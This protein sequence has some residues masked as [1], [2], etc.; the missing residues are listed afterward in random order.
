LKAIQRF[1]LNGGQRLK[2]LLTTHQFLPEYS[3]GTEILVFSAAKELQRKGTD[4]YVFTGFPECNA[5]DDAG[6]F[7]SY[8]YDEI[9]VERF[10]YSHVPMGEQL[11]I[12]EAEYNNSFVAAY[13]RGFLEK[14]KPDIVHF[15][16]LQRLSASVINVCH[17]LGI[18]MVLTPTDFWFV[19]PTIQLL[20]TDNSIC[21]G[22]N[23]N[24]V[25]CLRH[26]VALGQP[27]IMQSM[28]QMMP[29]VLLSFVVRLL[30]KGIFSNLRV[31]T[32]VRAL[33]LRPEFLRDCLNK[34]DRVIVPSRLTENILK[35][36][37]LLPDRIVFSPF[38]IDLSHPI[39]PA[40]PRDPGKLRIGY[41][42][43]LLEHKGAHIL[44]KAA[45]SLPEK[46]PFELKIYGDTENCPDF[47][48][49]LQLIAGKDKR[50]EFCGT[51]PNDQ[52]GKILSSLDVLVVP[53]I[54]LENTPLVIYSAQAYGCP[55]IASDLG[56]MSELIDH[57]VN[58]LLFR[59]G[60]IS[61]LAVTISRLIHDRQ[62]LKK[63]S[64]N[65]RKPKSVA[66]YV[67]ELIMVYC[68]ILNGRGRL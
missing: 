45:C 12:D 39:Y 4:V 23:R 62:L 9:P 30:G 29:D 36:H 35:E 51:F 50:L 20:L 52:I 40:A 42:G 1:P 64:Q 43:T 28:M 22:P 24:S 32:Y 3:A 31:A 46:E 58:G 8:V 68:E 66:A 53:S 26:K 34:V 17:E 19:C 59:P 37:G 47:V 5:L 67:E 18:P 41:I 14:L 61:G 15:F 44:L 16:H 13:F 56:G 6:R 27:Q 38:G 57:E 21:H 33:S 10:H 55:V 2:I 25:N 54:W 63:L 11:N 49:K 65:A 7:D 48:K 60:D